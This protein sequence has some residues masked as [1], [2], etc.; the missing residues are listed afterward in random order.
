M[1][2]SGLRFAEIEHYN[3]SF[4]KAFLD[5]NLPDIFHDKERQ[6]IQ[7][8][9]S[10]FLEAMSLTTRF[11]MAREGAH[12]STIDWVAQKMAFSVLNSTLQIIVLIGRINELQDNG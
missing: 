3:P 9:L 12:G 11:E 7:H 5:R 8:Q 6:M 10:R 2:H 4:Q 1:R